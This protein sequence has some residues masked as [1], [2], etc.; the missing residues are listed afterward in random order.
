VC[1]EVHGAPLGREASVFGSNGS[2]G[3]WAPRATRVTVVVALV[4]V[5]GVLAITPASSEAHP[6]HPVKSLHVDKWYQRYEDTYSWVQWMT[7]RGSVVYLS[8]FATT[9]QGPVEAAIGSYNDQ[10]APG[11]E[12]TVYLTNYTP[13]VY[14]DVR[15]TVTNRI[16][17]HGDLGVCV[18]T[19]NYLGITYWYDEVLHQCSNNGDCDSLHSRPNTWWYSFPTLD[20]DAHN[21]YPY[22]S[23]F[24]RQATAAHEFGH[25]IGIAHDGIG[26]STCSDGP[27][28]R[29]TVMD[30]D[31]LGY[32][33]QQHQWIETLNV[34]QA[35]DSCGINHK[36]YDP[37]WGYAGC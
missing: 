10:N 24:Q 37:N 2:L 34:P 18:D 21:S 3:A 31:C 8:N 33:N 20:N 26:D 12:H 32:Y 13:S 23:A 1:Q 11:G 30:Y 14:D 29:K 5:A 16:W 28:I 19:Q 9:W 4:F 36:Y 17:C 35:W 25:A 27:T 6:G 22:N 7:L 15:T